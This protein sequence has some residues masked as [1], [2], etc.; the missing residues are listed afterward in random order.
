M[1][2]TII[3]VVFTFLMYAVGVFV[4]GTALIPSL[5]LFSHV[6]VITHDAHFVFR[7][8]ILS[9]T[10][11]LGYFIFGLVLMFVVAL[12]RVILPL[13]LKEGEHRI[14]SPAMVQWM[15]A[16]ALFLLVRITFMDFIL[17]TPFCTFFYRLMGSKMGKNVQI[18]SKDV[19]DHCLLEIGDGAVIGGNATVIAHSFESKGLK[20]KKVV[21][22]KKAI[23]GLN[24]VIMPG[25]VI[26]DGAII[27]AGAILPKGSVVEPGAV[28]YGIKTDPKK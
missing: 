9:Y 24:S 17:L 20:L 8:F 28:Y 7:L 16:N 15:I 4:L 11:V 5:W 1:I 19:A 23:I 25:C 6:W 14:G 21:I 18:N 27:A 3:Q 2:L 13:Q 10:A 26:G 12:V 22:G